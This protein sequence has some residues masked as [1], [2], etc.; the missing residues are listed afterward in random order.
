MT[1]GARSFG[2]RG[3]TPCPPGERA[4]AIFPS[5]ERWARSGCPT[6]TVTPDL[7]P[8]FQPVGI[9]PPPAV[10]HGSDRAQ[11]SSGGDLA[12]DRHGDD[13]IPTPRRCGRRVGGRPRPGSSSTRARRHVPRSWTGRARVAAAAV[14]NLSEILFVADTN[15][16]GARRDPRGRRRVRGPSA[17]RLVRGGV[18][19]D[20]RTASSSPLPPRGLLP[21]ADPGP[22]GA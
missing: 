20:D 15:G 12:N 16:R 2:R 1:G 7:V 8:C 9:W 22:G 11:A 19:Q 5:V 21:D 6:P 17:T 18:A 3:R 4:M 14:G 13:G 10:P